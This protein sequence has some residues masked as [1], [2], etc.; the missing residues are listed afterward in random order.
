M[1]TCDRI[2]LPRLVCY[3]QNDV[4]FTQWVYRCVQCVYMC[5]SVCRLVHCVLSAD[6]LWSDHSGWMLIPD[7]NRDYD[8]IYIFITSHFI[9]LF[10]VADNIFSTIICRAATMAKI[11]ISITLK[12]KTQCDTVHSFSYLFCLCLS[13]GGNAVKQMLGMNHTKHLFDC[14]SITSY[15]MMLSKWKKGCVLYF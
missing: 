4:G 14:I 1:T 2:S 6:H 7:L 9:V 5:V 10:P 13:C 11:C 3:D 12:G 15:R 8:C